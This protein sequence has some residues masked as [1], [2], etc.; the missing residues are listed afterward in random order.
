MRKSLS[1]K[2]GRGLP[3]ML[4]V[5]KDGKHDE[6]EAEEEEEEEEESLFRG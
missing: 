5:G 4:R 6:E 2:S 3:D 1:V